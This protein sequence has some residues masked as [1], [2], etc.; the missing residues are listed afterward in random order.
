MSDLFEVPKL[1]SIWRLKFLKYGVDACRRSF[2][3]YFG[4]ADVLG[5]LRACSKMSIIVYFAQAAINSQ[6]DANAL[7]LEP[8]QSPELSFSV[9]A[10]LVRS[11][12][13]CSVLNSLLRQQAAPGIDTK[14][15]LASCFVHLRQTQSTFVDPRS[16]KFSDLR[17]FLE[18][19]QL[20]HSNFIRPPAS[21]LL[22]PRASTPLP[23]GRAWPA[24][25]ETYGPLL[26][27]SKDPVRA[28]EER[29]ETK[30]VITNIGRSDCSYFSRGFDA[31]RTLAG[32]SARSKSIS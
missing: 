28:D 17:M 20:F 22:A 16:F 18:Q 9:D 12:V 13:T 23:E 25:K 27:R 5:I 32:S 2:A 15:S 14:K 31:L 1:S 4:M 3:S 29:C 21:S 7:P 19:R 8:W 30:H 6:Q 11:S 10:I 26:R 24:C